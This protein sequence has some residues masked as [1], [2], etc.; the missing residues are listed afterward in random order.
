MWAVTGCTLAVF[1]SFPTSSW[2]SSTSPACLDSSSPASSVAPSGR[3]WA[4]GGG[5]V[6][7]GAEEVGTSD[8]NG[9]SGS[10]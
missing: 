5:G 7:G 6:G 3:C 9:Y 8:G 4:E 2:R 10:G 1:R